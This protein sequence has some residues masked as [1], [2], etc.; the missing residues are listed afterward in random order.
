[1]EDWYKVD[2]DI[3]LKELETNKDG[4]SINEVQKRIDKYGYN[5]IPKNNQDTIFKIFFRELK[6]PIVLLL[7]ITIIFCLFISEYIDAIAITLIVLIDLILGTI[8]EWRALKNADALSNMI[9]FMVNV[10]RDGKEQLIDSK[11][12]VVGDIVLVESGNKISADLRILESKNLQVNESV[13]TGESVAVLKDNKTIKKD[14]PLSDRNNMMFAGTSVLT[15]R[16]TAVVVGTGLN[17]EIGKIADNVTNTKEEESPL[18]IRMNKF[19]K[20]ISLLIVIVALVIATVL[21]IKGEPGK[22]IFLSVIALSVSAMPEGLP[23]ALTMALTIGAN[24]MSKKNVIVKRLNSVESLGSCTIIA[25]DKTGTLTVNEQ[26]AKKIVLPNDDAFEIE[27]GGY[28]DEG[29]VSPIG[30]AKLA[31]AKNL[32]TLATI[33]NEANIFEKN[34]KWEYFGDSIDVAFLFLSKKLNIDISNIEIIA[35]IPYESENK[36]SAVFY[37]VNHHIYCTVKGSIEKVLQLTTT[38][39]KDNIKLD[40]NKLLKQNNSLAQEGYRVIALAYKEVPLK[41]NYEEKDI[42]NLNFEGLCGFIDPVREEVK[43]SL[44]ET[45]N[46]GIKVVMITGDHPLTAYSIAKELNLATTEDEVATG[47]D[48]EKFYDKPESDLDEFIK[49]KKVFARI[50]PIDKLNI[51]NSYKRQGEYIAVTGDGVNDAPAL[52][53]ANIGIAMGSGTD[54][55]KEV[56]SMI[57]IDDNFKSIA[58]GIKEGRN[59][60][61]NIR[62]I[63]YMLISCGLAEVL[64]F[65]LSIIFNLPMPLVA[66]QLLWLNIVTDGLQDLALSFEKAE[67]KI[68]KEKPRNPKE[69]LFNKELLTEVLIS[70]IS[71]G[72]LVFGVWYFL[73]NNLAIDVKIARGYVMA[74]MV[75]IQNIHVLNCRSETQ[76]IFSIS[77]KNNPLVI[78]TIISSILLQIIVMEVPLLSMF[79]QTSSIPII[80]LGYLL[81]ISTS[82]LIIMEIYKYYKRIIKPITS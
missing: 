4:L 35:S 26:T 67:N 14:L 52:K 45:I 72:I 78:I 73:I 2:N 41:D 65:I 22:S 29:K 7:I 55:A 71:I 80:N 9:K 60:Y 69:T 31:D 33:N 66:I 42:K 10:I 24:R 68:M 48:L 39:G 70:G 53:S 38:M 25:S 27:G 8:Q 57:I 56:S 20:Q 23:L 49:T 50:T 61:S 82:I 54:V 63:S 62:K 3:V 81:L 15:G 19:S 79:L 75:F 37:R 46:A 6:D 32:I 64:F 30:E 1:M 44:K 58:A 77:F 47:Q 34:G 74:L 76:S 16:A 36:Y 51:V 59:A 18:T 40:K 28:N 13:L 21:F 12:L 43:D 17:T 5:E 11:Y